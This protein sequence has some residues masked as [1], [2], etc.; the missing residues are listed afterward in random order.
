MFLDLLSGVVISRL[1]GVVVGVC[2]KMLTGPI[3]MITAVVFV[4]EFVAWASNAGDVT[5]DG[6]MNVESLPG[7]FAFAINAVVTGICVGL[8]H[9]TKLYV[10][11]VVMT[12]LE[13]VTNPGS[14]KDS[15]L[16]C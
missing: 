2:V 8:L 16:F 9:D 11:L 13:F 6:V 15:L 1:S 14:P 3:A 7:T 12:V 5:T 10:L 4:L